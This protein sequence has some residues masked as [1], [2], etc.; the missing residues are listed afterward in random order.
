MVVANA[1]GLLDVV[2]PLGAGGSELVEY[3]LETLDLEADVMD[4]AEAA[5]ALDARRLI[6]LE[7]ENREVDVAVTQE[8][9]DGARVVDGA[10]LLH[11]ED[12]DVES[13]RPLHVLG[14][15]RDVLDLRHE[16]PP[17]S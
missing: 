14:G 5:A 15:E 10:H 3:R 7:I 12:L 17:Y 11:A 6:V 1:Q 8:A 9:A 4:A 2:A 16:E 13:G